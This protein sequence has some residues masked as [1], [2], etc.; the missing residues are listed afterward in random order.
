MS[1]LGK[2]VLLGTMAGISAIVIFVTTT[3]HI[4][5]LVPYIVLLLVV[6][7]WM[8]RTYVARFWSRFGITMAA[9]VVTTMILAGFDWAV[10]HKETAFI[11]AVL[12]LAKTFLI[13]AAVSLVIALVSGLSRNGRSDRPGLLHERVE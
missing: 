1:N 6:A 3:R 2:A 5:I 9:F 7:G 4:L 11:G 12:G 10:N 13:G 8:F